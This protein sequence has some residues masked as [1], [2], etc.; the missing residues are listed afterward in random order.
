MI[1]FLI[2]LLIL[3]LSFN[4]LLFW[5]TKKVIKE[6][7]VTVDMATTE[8]KVTLDNLKQVQVMLNEYSDG[9]LGVT[10][11]ETYAEDE[12]LT[13]AINNTNMVIGM[14]EAFRNTI[15]NN[16]NLEEIKKQ[17]ENNDER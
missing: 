8:L 11:L 6:A 5:Y 10:S 4:V 9:L 17:K 12:V 2:I 13:I 1:Y 14:C 15:I 7:K 3:S 16:S